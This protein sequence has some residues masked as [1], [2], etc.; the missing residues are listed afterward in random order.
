MILNISVDFDKKKNICESEDIGVSSHDNLLLHSLKESN[1]PPTT[2]TILSPH[3]WLEE[4]LW[5]KPIKLDFR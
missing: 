1:I 2:T 4:V 5:N 3:L